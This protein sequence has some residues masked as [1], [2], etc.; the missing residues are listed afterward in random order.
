MQGSSSPQ[1][2][3][4]QSQVSPPAHEPMCFEA[5]DVIVESIEAGG[6]NAPVTVSED[7]G[8]ANCAGSRAPP[9]VTVMHAPTGQRD[10]RSPWERRVGPPIDSNGERRAAPNRLARAREDK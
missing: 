8:S 7:P 4:G 5:S 3:E 10:G 2:A 6:D 9:T 1:G